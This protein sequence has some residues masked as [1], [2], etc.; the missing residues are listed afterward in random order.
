M[1][2]LGRY[3]IGDIIERL[4]CNDP[5]DYQMNDEI[6]KHGRLTFI[7]SDYKIQRLQSISVTY[8]VYCLICMQT[9]ETFYMSMNNSKAWRKIG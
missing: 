5:D 3:D 8:V 4:P 1:H 9:N 2:P 7:V 6:S